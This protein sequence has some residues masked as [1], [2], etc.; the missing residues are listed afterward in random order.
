MH[1]VAVLAFD[2]VMSFNLAIPLQVFSTAHALEKPPG[3]LFGPRLYDVRVCGEGREMSV[4]GVDH[5]EMYRY[6][7]PYSW[8]DAVEADTVVVVGTSVEEHPS[9]AALDV[10]REAHRRAIRIAS[11]CSGGALMLAAAGLLDGRRAAT[12]WASA[13]VLAERY[14][15]VEVD[16]DVLFIDHGDVL[17]SAGAATGLDLCL[18]MV[19]KDFG[20]AVAAD[21]ARH[22]VVPP[23]RDGGQAQFIAHPE[24]GDEDV[25]LEPTMR[26]VRERVGEPLSL[27]DIARHAGMSER[28]LNRRFREQTGTTP[29]QWLLRQRVH[30]AQEL[31]ET[32]DLSVEAISRHC[33]F[34]TS[35]A[36]RQHF[37]KHIRVSPLA[38]RRAFRARA[39]A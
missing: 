14:P 15:R 20:A 37:A 13:H 28:T 1:R 25:S 31:L 16:V 6:T 19:R 23:Q 27:A 9:D 32:T 11:I 38:Y 34:G 30:H 18:H 36:M 29:L 22:L 7:P 8:A 26:W 2:G 3:A 4:S 33:G 35:V 5:V 24:P 12:H 39:D 17:T 10:L 21:V